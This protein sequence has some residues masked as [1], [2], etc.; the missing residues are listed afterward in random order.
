MP[1]LLLSL[2]SPFLSPHSSHCVLYEQSPP[3]STICCCSPSPPCRCR[4]L[5]MQSS[6]QILLLSRLLFPS[7]FWA[8]HLDQFFI[9]HSFH[10]TGPFQSY[11]HQFL[12]K[13][14][15]IPS[16][17]LVLSILPLSSLFTTTILLI[18]LIQ[19]FPP[20]CKRPANFSIYK[21]ANLKRQLSGQCFP[22]VCNEIC[23][24]IFPDIQ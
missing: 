8:S 3:P 5:L 22:W 9:T 19:A 15:I 20:C 13:T 12:L 14:F 7:S 16:S 10:M 21:F 1:W 24:N 17:T 11:L 2:S 6:N 4:S 23:I 18:Q